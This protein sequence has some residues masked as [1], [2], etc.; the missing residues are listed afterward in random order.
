MQLDP[1]ADDPSFRRVANYL[2]STDVRRH[3]RYCACCKEYEVGNEPS[4][5]QMGEFLEYIKQLH[6]ELGGN[7]FPNTSTKNLRQEKLDHDS[8]DE[9]TDLEEPGILTK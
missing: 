7:K 2:L 8:I 4:A 6:H 3:S 1:K 9:L 5:T